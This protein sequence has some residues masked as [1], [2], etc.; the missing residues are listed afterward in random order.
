MPDNRTMAKLPKRENREKRKVWIS[1]RAVTQ[2][3]FAEEEVEII[4]LEG[5]REM[6]AV[7]KG[8]LSVDQYYHGRDFHR[9]EESAIDDALTRIAKKRQ[10]IAKKAKQLDKLE[11]ELRKRKGEL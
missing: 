10:S 1:K 4:P 5:G 9:T 2:G 3:V 8:G 11:A 7:R 6:A